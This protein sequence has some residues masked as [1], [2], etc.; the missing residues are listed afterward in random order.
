MVM[1]VTTIVR[2]PRWEFP[3]LRHRQTFCGVRPFVGKT[4]LHTQFIKVTEGS[5]PEPARN[6]QIT[7]GHQL[8]HPA[9]ARV[10]GNF[11]LAGLTTREVPHHQRISVAKC[12][13][14]GTSGIQ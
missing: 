11:D 1:M 2:L 8:R 12:A 7:I 4:D 6:Q 13:H 9:T 10:R 14:A 5:I 3:P